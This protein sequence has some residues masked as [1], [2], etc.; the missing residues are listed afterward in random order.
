MHEKCYK[1]FRPLKTCYCKWITPIETGVK[2][3][4]L[5][6]PQEAYKQKTGTGRLAK[7]SL[8]DSDL[9]IDTGF[10]DHIP[11]NILL[12][13]PDYYPVILYPGIDTLQVEDPCFRVD[14]GTKK[15]LV[16]IIDATWA[17]SRKM[18]YLSPNLGN[19]PKI[20]FQTAYRSQ[21]SIKRQPHPHCL[22]TIESTYYLIH[23]LQDAG[24]IENFINPEGLMTV[25]KK[26]V[27]FQHSHIPTE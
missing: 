4:F 23:E 11:V 18:M 22:S 12:E 13:N 25:F 27:A 9:I 17:K 1:C 7:L 8:K 19:L 6:H 10:N 26:M 5:M 24:L 21:F 14:M 3:V 20:S 2:F 15:L 16:F